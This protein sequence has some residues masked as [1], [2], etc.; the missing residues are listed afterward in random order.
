MFAVMGH[1]DDDCSTLRYKKHCYGNARV[2]GVH[3]GEV[4]HAV[5]H[6]VRFPAACVA[7]EP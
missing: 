2:W 3:E 5:L 6:D 7:P 4:I 1:A